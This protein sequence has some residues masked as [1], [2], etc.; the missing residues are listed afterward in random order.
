MKSKA[1]CLAIFTC[2]FGLNSAKGN[3]LDLLNNRPVLSS[4]MSS[5]TCNSSH[6]EAIQLAK[7]RATEKAGEKYVQVGNWIQSS[8]VWS[9]WYGT[10]EDCAAIRGNAFSVFVPQILSGAP[11][12]FSF[13][14]SFSN[15]RI[16]PE[17]GRDGHEKSQESA[18]E[19]ARKSAESEIRRL[20][21]DV[22]SIRVISTSITWFEHPSWYD[23]YTVRL[24][25]TCNP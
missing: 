8:Y 3:D 4:G 16:N 24:S 12:T 6:Q 23:P 21:N 17:D 15:R 7:Q 2:V 11:Y 1:L 13:E 19:E 22:R 14:R 9:G 25:A 18:W 10:P 20:C 5:V